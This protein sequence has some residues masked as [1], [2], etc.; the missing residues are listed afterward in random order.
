MARLPRLVL[1]G[2]PHHVTQRGNRRE[3]TFFE[4]GDYALY[5]DLLAEAAGRAHVEIGAYCLM[6]NHIHVIAALQELFKPMSGLAALSMRRDP[7]SQKLRILR[8]D[9]KRSRDEWS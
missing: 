9:L 8:F 2:I 6:P 1:P 5:L 3:Q 7:E 4:E